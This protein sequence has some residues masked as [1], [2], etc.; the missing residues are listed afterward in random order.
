MS[1]LVEKFLDDIRDQCVDG[2]SKENQEGYD[3][4]VESALERLVERND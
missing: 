4:A 2:M 1:K 3:F